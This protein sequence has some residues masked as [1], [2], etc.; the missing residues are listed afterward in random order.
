MRTLFLATLL[1]FGSFRISFAQNTAILSGQV[2]DPS[3]AGVSGAEVTLSNVLTGFHRD[4]VSDADGKFLLVNIPFQSYSLVVE[5]AGFR[6]DQRP[7][8]LRSNIPVAVTVELKLLQKVESLQVSAVETGVLVDAESTGTRTEL[9]LSAIEKM[10]AQIGSRGM[11]A[12][13]LS[14]PGFAANANG[15]IHP[16]G[17]HNQMSYVID[18]M[19]IS[20]QLTGSF[21]TSVDPS[22]VQTVELF[23]GN[24]P[25]EFGSKISGVANITTRSGLETGKPFSGSIQLGASQFDTLSNV[26]QFGGKTGRLGYFASFHTLKSNRFLDQVSLDNLH[27]GGNSERAFA[28]MDLQSSAVDHVRLNLMAGRSSFQLANLRSQHASGQ[29][30]RQLLRDASVSLAW[31]RTLGSRATVDSNVSYRTSIAQLLPSAGDTPVTASQARHL[32]T[33]SLGS[34]LNAL[35]GAHTLRVGLDYQYF[36]VSENFS[37]GITSGV[38]NPPGSDGFI[39]TLLAHD[40]SR[41]GRLFHFSKEAAGQLSSVFVQDQVRLGRFALS[42]GLRYDNYRFLV[43]GNQLQPRV[44]M[45]F[46]LQE[47]GTV[48]RASYNRTYQT[49]PNENLLLSNSE[50]SS[51]LVPPH[52]RQTLGGALIRIR[53][54]RQNVYE[55]GVQQAIGRHASLNGS[56]YHKDSTD[57]QDNDNFFNTGIIFPTSLNRSSVNGAELRLAVPRLRSFSGSLSLTHFHV[58]VTPPFTGGLFLGSTAIDLLTAGPF[59]ID[60]DQKLG[61]QGMLRYEVSKAL[62]V[63]TALRHDSGLVSNPSDPLQVAN[64]PDYSDLLPYVNLTSNPPRVRPRAILDGGIGYQRQ[65]EGRTRWDVQFQVTN[66]TNRTA[67]YNFQSI[68]VGTRLV[69]PRTMGVK[70]RWFW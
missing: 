63:S 48:F 36:P 40:L 34:R 32:S 41:G 66:L 33:L 69:Q 7:V 26:T 70:L 25:A 15:A 10:P 39:P 44:G 59:V 37:F 12:L 4:Q 8:V 14:F 42:L 67:A 61:V 53:P 30:Q 21:A 22:I 23:T 64:D 47:T 43:R 51:V 20:D 27:N 62:W 45:S 3:G 5:K 56:F 19:V 58:V 13:L 68:F 6:S 65:R 29:Q 35:L 28:R 60:H 52:V 24:I 50:E 38:F 11:E 49:P 17:A 55:V 1:F 54:E 2:L 9:N 57:M 46:Y 31:L 16:R 18:G